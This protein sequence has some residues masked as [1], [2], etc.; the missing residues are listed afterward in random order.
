M[1]GAQ[2]RLLLIGGAPASGKTRLANEL[3]GRYGGGCCSKDELKEVLF[4]ALGQGDAR[5]SRRLSD[6]SFA[7]LF[8]LTP[9]LLAA[10]GLLLLE[11]NFRAGEHE[12]PLRRLLERSAASLA[13]VLC[14]ANTATRAAR[15]AARV[16]DPDRHPGHRDRQIDAAAGPAAG[17]LELPGQRLRFDSDAD[18]ARELTALVATLDRW[19]PPVRFS[20]P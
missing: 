18:W 8:A 1:C 9:K 12:P 2:A 3:A 20:A 16:A 19:C 11:G 13:Q 7:L 4:D 15:L 14:V 10:H 6:A 17:F 5:W